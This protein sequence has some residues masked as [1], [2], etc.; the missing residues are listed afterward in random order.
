MTTRIE[1]VTT[2]KRAISIYPSR[3][4]AVA[5]VT[6]LAVANIFSFIDRQILSLLIDPIRASLDIDDVQI[7]ILIGPVFALFYGVMGIPLGWAVD[8]FRRTRLAAGGIALWSLMTV[9]GGFAASFPMLLVSRVGVGVGEAVLVPAAN[10]IIADSFPPERRTRAMGAFAMSIYVGTG[11]ALVFGGLLVGLVSSGAM[12]AVIPGRLPWQMVLILVGAPGVLV[13]AVLALLPEPARHEVSPVADVAAETI[14]PF[15]KSR[16]GALT[17]HFLGYSALIL[18]GYSL[19]AWAPSV[20]IRQYHWS[21]PSTGLALGLVGTIAGIGAIWC[22]T[23]TADRMWARGARNGL[24]RIGLTGA[25]IGL[26]AAALIGVVQSAGAFI[27][28]YGVMT[29]I[30]AAGIGTGAAAIQQITPNQF[31]GRM[32]GTYLLIASLIGSG[33][34]PPAIALLSTHVFT[35]SH[36]LSDGLAMTCAIAT[37]AAALAFAA[38]LKPFG[39]AVRQHI[40]DEEPA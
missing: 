39:A 12:Q 11:L 3:G 30:A 23:W 25:L 36:A 4:V 27:L 14:L 16:A 17:C 34:G 15:V 32:L 28:G 10:S 9:L 21:A 38:G 6:V 22:A 7:S 5:M 19:N 1:P 31:R 24:F 26:P 2:A 37:V 20:L 33:L 18:I 29:A 40:V 35:S 13:A 8:R